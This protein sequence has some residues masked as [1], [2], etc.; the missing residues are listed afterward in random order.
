MRTRW[1]LIG[2]FCGGMF[3]APLFAQL[4]PGPLAEAHQHLSGL[5]NCLTCHT[6]GSKDLS[7]RCLEC[8]T[9][10]RDRIVATKGFHGQLTEKDCASCHSDHLGREFIMI[11]WES[12]QEQFD[13][14]KAGFEIKGKHQE[15]ECEDCHKQSLIIAEDILEYASITKSRDVLN[16]TFLGLGI[17]CSNC[18]EDVHLNEFKDQACQ[19]CHT[20]ENW[21]DIRETFDH[22]Q[23]T[24]FPLRGAH[25]NLECEK[26]HKNQQEPVGKYQSQQFSNLSFELCTDCHEDEHKNSFGNNC[27]K[28]HSVTTFKIKDKSGV[29]NH[30]ET[31]Y[32]LVGEHS[33]VE[34]ETCH[35][36]ED[37]FV[38]ETSFD[39]CMDCHPDYHKS[40]FRESKRN[41]SCDQCHSI[42]G[43]FPPLFGMN[44][45]AKTRFPL[46]GAHL[47]QPC[48][49]CH[50]KADQA[51]YQWEPLNCESCHTTVH[52]DQFQR[53]RVNLNFCENCHGSSAWTDLTFDH[54]ATFFP[55][56]GKHLELD[57]NACHTSENDITQ[58]ENQDYDCSACH[59]DVHA[60]LFVDS[61]CENCH[62]T[63]VWT[64]TQFDHASKTQF[65]LDGKHDQ[66]T[67]G[68]CHKFE[69]ALN[70][71]RFKPI[72]HECQDCHSFGDFKE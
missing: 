12:S 70:T 52:G 4:S 17:E 71:I 40:T 69:S 57:C 29:I 5:T 3:H 45:H 48:I 60:Q 15:L 19:E 56:T 39:Q 21:L 61:A 49:F 38:L 13:H 2:L 63:S 32:P 42:Q 22:N 62:T 9:P 28:C 68:Q 33:K 10:I 18:H 72:A 53:Y 64:I 43:F 14:S 65:P 51:V 27:L 26:C 47:A 30:N 55:L 37:R 25:G 41:L 1:I 24:E 34:C 50:K 67:C 23:R 7:P 44:E 66:L 16:S 20:E 36:S 54:Q 6:W 8:H 35:T 58:Y 31:R 46:Q 11:E 59:R